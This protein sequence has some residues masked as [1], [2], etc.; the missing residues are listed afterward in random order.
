VLRFLLR[1][2]PVHGVKQNVTVSDNN[3]EL[4]QPI[5]PNNVEFP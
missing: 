2:S 5:K 3:S 4:E 1:H